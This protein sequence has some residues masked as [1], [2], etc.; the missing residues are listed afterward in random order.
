[1]V[2]VGV[3]GG[4]QEHDNCRTL[5]SQNFHLGSTSS[6]SV[7]GQSMH[8]PGRIRFGN[9]CTPTSRRYWSWIACSFING[10]ISDLVGRAIELCELKARITSL[11]SLLL[12]KHRRR[13]YTERGYR[14]KCRSVSYLGFS[15]FVEVKHVPHLGAT[16]HVRII[17][18]EKCEIPIPAGTWTFYRQISSCKHGQNYLLPALTGALHQLTGFLAETGHTE[19]MAKKGTRTGV[20]IFASRARAADRV[21]CG[22]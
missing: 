8:F 11:S 4:Q 9:L 21:S 10:F 6:S 20:C 2:D 16:Q 15:A 19:G 14:V 13:K 22:F 1:M 7:R 12:L 5:L 18:Q 17:I 3:Q